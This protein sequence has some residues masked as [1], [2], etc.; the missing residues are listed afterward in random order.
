MSNAVDAQAS[1]EGVLKD[2]IIRMYQEV[3]ENPEG[4]FHFFHGRKAAEMFGY[5]SDWLDR[6]PV[7]AVDTFAG[8]GN[9]H[10]RSNLQPG[11]TV[12]DLG[13]G[14]GLDAIIAAWQV[15]PTGKVVGVDLNPAMCRKIQTH[16][17]A[18]GMGMECYEGRM[19]DIPLSNADVDVIISNGV[20]NL[21]FRKRKVVEEMY[22]VL[23][24]DGRISITD[25]VSAKQLSQ[26][27]V[28]DPK[29]WAS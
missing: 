22:R 17:S 12:L 10:E 8:V 27:I 21:S 5:S 6:A 7:G 26:S 19:E 15:G 14:A 29:L 28:N 23:K 3:A 20:I 16:A 2:E 13:S 4:E 25:I 18:T 1:L 24:P 11:E 9:P